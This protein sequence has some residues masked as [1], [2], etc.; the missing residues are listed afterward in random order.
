MSYKNFPIT[1]KYKNAYLAVLQRDEVILFTNI[2]KVGV[3][4]YNRNEKRITAKNRQMII[5]IATL[6]MTIVNF[7]DILIKLL[8][9]YK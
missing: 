6:L 8:F 1:G 9:L 3:C 5:T 7:P 2:V 4:A